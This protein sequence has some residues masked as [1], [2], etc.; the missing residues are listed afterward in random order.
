MSFSNWVWAILA[1][2]GGGAAVALALVRAFG[3]RWLDNRFEGK[4]QGLRHEHDRQMEELR[5]KSSQS[6]DRSVK[7]TEREFEV[8]AEAWSLVF[9]TYVETIGALPGLRR[10]VDLSRASDGVARRVGEAAGF[11]D[12]EI[13]ELLK[14]RPT[15]RN[16]F[17]S[18]RREA[19]QLH[20]A[21]VAN[22]EAGNYLAKKA[23]FIRREV[24]DRLKT[25]VDEA[26]RALVAW[27]LVRE[28]R[29][30]GPL[31]EGIR[32]DDEEFR[33]SADEKIEELENFVRSKF[34]TDQALPTLS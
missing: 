2:G 12:F 23:L 30:G 16:A 28:I 22:S 27:E 18:E 5:L 25:F 14:E 10:Y 31:P 26:W 20:K 3:S 21:K 34:W 13:N 9:E 32:R 11:D 24:H 19:H 33:K 1:S 4:L 8:T 7:L 6:L 15:D 29:T 17:Y